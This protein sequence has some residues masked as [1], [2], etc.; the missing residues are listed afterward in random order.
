[1]NAF[2]YTYT[3]AGEN[4]A[5]GY[6]DAQ[7]ALNQWI[8]AC[9]ADSS[10]NCTYAHRQNM[11]NASFVVIGIGRAYNASSLY[12]WYWT[13]DFGG[14]VD[15]TIN[16]NNPPPSATGLGFFPVTPC[17]MVDTRASQGKTGAFGPPALTAYHGRDFPL[18]S[19][20]CG[21]PSTAQAYSLNF[22]VVPPGPV[23]FLSAWPAGQVFPNI[24]TL[25]SPDGSIRANAAI[26]P[27]GTNGAITVTAG[28]S[29]DLVIDVNGYFASPNGQELAF[30]TMTPCRVVDTRASQ[31][32]TGAFGPP[33]LAPYTGRDFPILSSSCNIPGWAEAY[34]LNMTVVPPG[35]LDFLST[36]PAGHTYPAV[37]TLNSTRGTTLANAAIVPAGTGGDIMVTAGNSTDLII[38][39][40]G[41]FGP[42]GGAGA[43]HYYPVTPCRVADT[44]A[45]QGKTGAFGPPSLVAYKGR[46][47]P[48]A[49]SCGVPSSAKAYALN[50]TVV[51]QGPLSFLS[52]WPS[53]QTYPGVST[54][55]STDGGVLANAA[56]VPA[57]TNGAVSVVAGNP[58]DVIIDVNGYFAP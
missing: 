2:G 48:I 14:V 15:Q 29:T 17:R 10:G 52:I 1:M 53:S 49:G 3:P 32:K 38:D 23:D 45:S 58:T 22:T 11:L 36:W 4:I 33:A 20:G 21:V 25:N 37:S 57:G 35:P 55:N 40:N 43:L 41:Y 39:M 26:V 44:R 30:Y 54:L 50:V 34:S 56:I 51:P 8:N 16:T 47:F 28:E 13:T 19:S 42:P 12:G 31:G 24:S 7:S 18:L 27:A 46:D 6:S 9:D 5:A